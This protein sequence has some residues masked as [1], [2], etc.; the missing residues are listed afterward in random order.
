MLTFPEHALRTVNSTFTMMKLSSAML[1]CETVCL[2]SLQEHD[3][4][5]ADRH[6]CSH[7]M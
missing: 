2:L 1:I 7:L 4:S 6:M 3:L 5:T